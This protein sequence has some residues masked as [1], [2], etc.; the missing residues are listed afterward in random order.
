VCLAGAEAQRKLGYKE[1]DIELAAAHDRAQ[2]GN[3]MMTLTSD[4][5]EQ[6]LY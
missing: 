3:H 1:A 5:E 6:V 2:S 4:P